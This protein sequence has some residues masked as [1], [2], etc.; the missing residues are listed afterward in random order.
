MTSAGGSNCFRYVGWAS[1]SRRILSALTVCETGAL[2]DLDN[3]T[4]RIADV[5]AN[6]SVLG[7]WLGDELGSTALPELEARLNI[8]NAEIHKA[9]D[10]IR[11]GDAE[12]YRRLIGSRPAPDVYNHPEIRELKVTRRIA[13]TSAQDASPEHLLVVTKRPVDIGDGEKMRDADPLPRRHL[14][15][16]LFDLYAVH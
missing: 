7:N 3:V 10:V 8:R 5:A 12:R 2:P 6:L 14:I 15:A 1:V 9:V 13:I 11:V 16:L 4:I